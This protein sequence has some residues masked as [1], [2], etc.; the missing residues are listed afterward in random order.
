LVT[1]TEIFRCDLEDVTKLCYNE[2]VFSKDKY[3]KDFLKYR[4]KVTDDCAPQK[5]LDVEIKTTGT[6]AETVYTLKPYQDITGCDDTTNSFGHELAKI[7]DDEDLPFQN[8]LYGL[9]KTVT[10]QV[11]EVDPVIECGFQDTSK[12]HVVDKKTLFYYVDSWDTK[13]KDANFFYKV[14][15]NCPADVQVDVSIKSNELETGNTMVNLYKQ[16][17][18]G[19]V[20][21]PKLYFTPTSCK[22]QEK[23][24]PECE[25]DPS[26]DPQLRFYEITVIA[27]DSAGRVGTDT[28]RIVVVPRCNCKCDCG[29]ICEN[30]KHPCRPSK[31]KAKR[32]GVGANGIDVAHTYGNYFLLDYVREVVD[33]STL[34][35]DIASSALVWEDGLDLPLVLVPPPTTVWEDILY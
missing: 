21:Q 29:E 33:N 9:P 13:P 19:F 34:R 10:L 7:Q 27:T 28:C 31:S 20:Q 14:T 35:Y 5:Y 25:A 8:P 15:E 30:A 12:I 22:E 6:C 11:D 1:N 4:M 18:S 17:K 24:S 3:A 2:K 26:I 16:Q 32:G 23:E